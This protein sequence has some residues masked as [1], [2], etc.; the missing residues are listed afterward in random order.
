MTSNNLKENLLRD[1]DNVVPLVFK[2]DISPPITHAFQI[3]GE[4][5]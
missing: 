5:N 2:N 1:P 3:F 4:P